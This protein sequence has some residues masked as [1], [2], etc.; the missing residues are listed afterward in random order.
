MLREDRKDRKSGRLIIYIN[1]VTIRGQLILAK[2]SLFVLLRRK[3]VNET[4]GVDDRFE[5]SSSR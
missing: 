2:V 5:F 3:L 1:I 4:D